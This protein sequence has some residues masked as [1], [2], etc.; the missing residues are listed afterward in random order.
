MTEH[1]GI[2]PSQT[3]GPFFHFGLTPTASGYAPPTT[4]DAVVAAPGAAGT[5]ITLGG[6]VFDGDGAP[7]SDAMIELWQADATG[8]YGAGASNGFRG[9]G[10]S[11]TGGDGAYR[12]ETTK[13]GR[14]AGPG[15]ALQAPHVALIVFAR[16]LLTHLFTRVYFADEAANATDPILALVPPERRGTLMARLAEPGVYVFDIHLQGPNETV[17][18]AA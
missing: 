1:R 12:F 7:V 3:V 8:R 2:S 16:G 18:F 9:F 5:P 4:I 11:P 6:R 15:G 17:F 13:P 10:R 14:V